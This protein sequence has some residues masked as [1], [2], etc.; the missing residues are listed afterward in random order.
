MIEYIDT[1]SYDYKVADISLAQ[2]GR[3]LIENAK[4]NMPNVKEMLDRYADIKPL[5]GIC[6]AASLPIGAS[7]AVM[8]E[9]LVRLGAKVRCGAAAASGTSN[10]VA[11]AL[12]DGGVP[13][14]AWDG[15]SYGEFWWCLSRTLDFGDDECAQYV[16]DTDGK[17][18]MII[19]TGKQSEVNP[20]MLE[21]DYSDRGDEF[22]ELIE[23]LFMLH[24]NWHETA[25][26]I[27]GAPVGT[28]A[29]EV[30]AELE[31]MGLRL[32]TM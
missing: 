6:V 26:S 15:E 20:S 18:N 3:S 14:F 32:L 30:L 12:A 29:L 4:A 10:A 19:S 28:K 25:K 24:R 23:T 9:M 27:S 22:F 17:L 11:A 21:Q 13:V 16:I 2:E 31:K 7:E 8:V 1:N 5:E